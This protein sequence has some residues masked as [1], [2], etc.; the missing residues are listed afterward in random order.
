[1]NKFTYVSRAIG[2][3]VTVAMVA[4]CGSGAATEPTAAAPKSNAMDE[5]IHNALPEKIREAGVITVVASG[6]RPPFWMTKEG[7]D[8][9]IGAGADLM[10][11]VGEVMGVDVEIVS[12]PDISGA[13]AAISS[14]RYA[15]GFPYADMT[16][17]PKERPGA[18]FVDV[19]LEVVPFLVKAGNPAGVTS[20]DELCDVTAAASVNAAT[21]VALQEQ[22]KKCQAEG[23]DLQVLAV[24]SIPDGVLAIKSGRADAFFTGG[25]PLFYAAKESNGELEVVGEDAGNGFEGSFMGALLPEGSALT[26]PVLDA[27]QTLFDNGRYEEIMK[28]WGLDAQIID[29]PGI[30]LYAE[31]L[32]EQS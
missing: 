14:G 9:Y 23:K 28:S 13:F 20:L 11:A 2:V 6:T 19:L 18:E 21:H 8:E 1:M 25:A 5:S 3:A 22:A 29:E 15:F 4:G 24:E 7:D 30:N 12:L 10:D 26:K 17:G 27:F 32:A 31:W 16:G